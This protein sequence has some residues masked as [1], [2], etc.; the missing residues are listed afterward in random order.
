MP[1]TRLSMAFEEL[2]G[3]LADGVAYRRNGATALRA[4]P[5]YKYPVGPAVAQGNR[6]L[7]EANRLYDTLS[8]AE[9]DLWTAYAE[10]N[11]KTDPMTGARYVPV[12][13]SLFVGLV[14]KCLQIRPDC[15]PPLLPPPGRLARQKLTIT[16]A[17]EEGVLR[18]A[19]SA[20]THPDLLVELMVQPLANP[21]RKPGRFYKSRGFV[22]FAPGSLAVD[23]PLPPGAYA[24]AVQ[25]V[26][27]STGRATG[28]TL[29]GKV[30]IA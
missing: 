22:A 13:K 28:F 19:A 4:K 30:E 1:K 11:P 25:Q 7:V 18:F 23:L 24:V 5:D 12:G 2:A 3:S 20:P 26:E 27:P 29:L 16:V 14:S 10:R 9:A 6:R 17:P 8:A 15:A 21:R